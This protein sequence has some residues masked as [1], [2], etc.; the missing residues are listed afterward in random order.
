MRRE[1][2]F[3]KDCKRL[4]GTPET[5]GRH[6]FNAIQRCETCQKIHRM[7]Y[8]ADYQKEYRK[9]GRTVRRLQKKQI[10]ILTKQNIILEQLYQHARYELK[11]KMEE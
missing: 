10:E 8:K 4:L 11:E 6:R 9:D 5:L 7:T 2:K 3:C 1:V